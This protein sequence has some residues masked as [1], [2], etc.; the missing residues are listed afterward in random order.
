MVNFGFSITSLILVLMNFNINCDLYLGLTRIYVDSSAMGA[1]NGLTWD[2]AFTDFQDALAV[3]RYCGVDTILVAKGTY[4][5]SDT[6]AIFNPCNGMSEIL[7]PNRSV[8][9]N[10]PDSVIVLAG[11][12]SGGGSLDQRIGFV[13]KRFFRGYRYTT[14]IPMNNSL[15]CGYK[16]QMSIQLLL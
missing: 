7:G 14:V 15:S 4:F 3:V 5:P 1:N 2:S 10:I 12:P 11:F 8:S 9:F 16:L 6:L 13:I